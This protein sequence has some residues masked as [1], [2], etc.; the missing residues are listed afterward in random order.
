MGVGNC[1]VRGIKDWKKCILDGPHSY[2]KVGEWGQLAEM[3]E[4]REIEASRYIS[5]Q[6]FLEVHYVPKFPGQNGMFQIRIEGALF[7][8]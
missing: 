6:N 1:K 4:M 3:E 8:L 2:R 7:Y 5:I